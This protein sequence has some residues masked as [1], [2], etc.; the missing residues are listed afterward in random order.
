[1]VNFVRRSFY[2]ILPDRLWETTDHGAYSYRE[3]QVFT[4]LSS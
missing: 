1:V 3:E 4:E 2:V